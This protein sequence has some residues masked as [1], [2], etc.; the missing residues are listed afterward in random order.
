MKKLLTFATLAISSTAFAVGVETKTL[1][2]LYADAV[3]EGGHLVVYAGGDT[4]EQ[5]NGIKAAFEKRF[6]KMKLD[7]I[8][9]YSKIHDA[10]I[11]YQLE[12][13]QLK[14]DVVQL[15]TL[16]D[17]PRWKAQGVLLNY[18]PLGWDKVYADFK[19]ADGAWTGV[20]VD[21]FSN[22][23]NAEALGDI[24]A[25]KEA[26]DYLNPQLKGKIISTYPNDDDAVLYWYKQTIDQYGWQWMGKFM[27]QQ[28]HF[29]RGTQD[30]ADEVESGKYPVT[31]S[32]DGGLTPDA[33]TKA[34]FHLPTEGG[35]VAWAQRAAIL[36]DAKNKAAA[37]LYLSWL[38]DKETQQN[39]W[40]MWSVRTDVPAPQG[41]KPIWEYK[42]ANLKGFE[43]FMA[44][45]AE[46]ERF[47]GKIALFVGDVKGES[48]AGEL[49]LTPVKA[50]R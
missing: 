32:T 26:N 3:K 19:D 40:Y 2:Q 30:P 8:V 12:T 31:F 43:N 41:Y 17:Y 23:S 21:A 48:S 1:D 6:P 5:Q 39:V 36:K 37:K 14:A 24:P 42:N 50:L 38:L 16:Q 33:S 27:Q 15:Q 13:G 44:D 45:R 22:L 49:G 46:V 7:T 11:D 18:K 10:R 47:K 20:F 35:F 25:P 9:D 34:R 4:P 28:P 29:V